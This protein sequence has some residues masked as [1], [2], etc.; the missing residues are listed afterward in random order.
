MGI[1]NASSGLSGWVLL[2]LLSMVPIGQRSI[3]LVFLDVG[4][5]E[6]GFYLALADQGIGRSVLMAPSLVQKSK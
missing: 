1:P 2:Y 3:L 6:N 5:V 4:P